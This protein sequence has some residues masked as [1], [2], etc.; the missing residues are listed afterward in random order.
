MK[1]PTDLIHP[2]TVD[3]VMLFQWFPHPAD[4]KRVQKLLDDEFT[5]HLRMCELA[6]LY[7]ADLDIYWAE[8]PVH[9]MQD[10]NVWVDRALADAGFKIEHEWTAGEMELPDSDREG[11]TRKVVESTFRTTASWWGATPLKPESYEKELERRRVRGK[12]NGSRARKV[13]RDA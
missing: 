12:G 10:V 13:R 6:I 8:L 1:R 2:L 7:H 5:K 4:K 3:A 11:K 9:P